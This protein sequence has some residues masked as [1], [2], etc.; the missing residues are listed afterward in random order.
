[1]RLQQVEALRNALLT[2]IQKY[3]KA[4]GSRETGHMGGFKALRHLMLRGNPIDRC[5][6]RPAT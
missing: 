2:K 4:E 6:G 3:S 5:R 1:M